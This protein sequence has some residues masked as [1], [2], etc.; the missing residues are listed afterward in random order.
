LLSFLPSFQHYLFML[1]MFN[2]TF[3]LIFFSS[4]KMAIVVSLKCF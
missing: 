1:C 2:L 3:F 4:F